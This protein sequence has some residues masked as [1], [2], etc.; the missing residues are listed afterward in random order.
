MYT[1]LID[2]FLIHTQIVKFSNDA[3]GVV[4]AAVIYHKVVRVEREPIHYGGY[5]L[6][7]ISQEIQNNTQQISYTNTVSLCIYTLHTY[8]SSYIIT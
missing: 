8:G 6:H 1:F 7:S 4:A 2:T 5:L 3:N